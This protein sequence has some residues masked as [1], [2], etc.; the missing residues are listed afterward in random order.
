VSVAAIVCSAGALGAFSV[1]PNTNV[2]WG[3]NPTT[4]KWHVDFG[5]GAS[6]NYTIQATAHE[7]IEYIH[8]ASSSTVV[9]STDPD[10][11]PLTV[12]SIGPSTGTTTLRIGD[13]IADDDIGTASTGGG[14]RVAGVNIEL[15]SSG[16]DLLGP[17]E[18]TGPSDADIEKLVFAN[19]TI[20]ANIRND[21]GFIKTLIASAVV[22]PSAQNPVTI[23]C[24]DTLGVYDKSAATGFGSATNLRLGNLS[25]HPNML[26]GNLAVEGNFTGEVNASMFDM[27]Y[28]NIGVGAPALQIGGDFTGTMN[29]SGGLRGTVSAYNSGANDPCVP[30]RNAAPGDYFEGVQHFPLVW[31]GGSLTAG[32]TIS[33]PA[34]TPGTTTPNCQSGGLEALLVVNANNNAYPGGRILGNVLVGGVPIDFQTG[35][36]QTDGQFTSL[37]SALGYGSVSKLP[38]A[39]HGHASKLYLLSQTTPRTYRSFSEPTG[40]APDTVINV[41]SVSYSEYLCW[42]GVFTGAVSS[43]D[44]KGTGGAP[45]HDPSEVNSFGLSNA[46]E[47]A[48]EYCFVQIILWRNHTPTA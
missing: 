5:T 18:V 46:E 36:G 32:S 30:Q 38:L 42:Q 7:T 13:F 29:L 14:V 34:Y 33:L 37:P 27:V 4:G 12:E 41:P 3:Q 19:G 43:S 40:S 22:G 17:I 39:I 25:W 31:L 1:S 45:I 47:I 28:G 8:S 26:I 9:V 44:N 48:F 35:G 21:Y 6:G 20:R 2:T 10:N 24:R 11:R 23:S 16:G 15:K